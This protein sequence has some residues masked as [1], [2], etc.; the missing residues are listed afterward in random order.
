MNK[1]IFFKI[2]KWVGISF[3]AFTLVL[4]I[5]I[6][7]VMRPKA[8]TDRTVAMAR[9]DIK[10]DINADDANNITAWLYQQ[11]GVNHVLCN[12]QTD[13]VVFTFHPTQA[14][15]N[16][17]ATRLSHTFN[18]PAQRYL[19]SEKEMQSGCPVAATSLTYKTYIFLKH[20]VN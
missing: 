14:D 12:P 16:N 5:H 8:P 4:A 10:K 1:K 6:Y 7:W 9:I 3:A 15:A 17:I 18:L 13:I 2:L 19:P 20:L 11:K